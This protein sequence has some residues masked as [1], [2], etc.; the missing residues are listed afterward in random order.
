MACRP[1]F[2]TAP[3]HPNFVEVKLVEFT[4]YAG[5]S[6]SQK[7]K[8]IDSLHSEIVAPSGEILE[9]SSKSREELGV[10]LSA[11]NLSFV[12]AKYPNSICIESAFQGSKVFEH[13]GPLHHL[14][15]MDARESKRTVREESL[16]SILEFNFFG[17]AWPTRPYT[18]FYDWIYMQALHRNKK[19]A[20]QLL[21]RSHFTDIE[22]NPKKS[23]NC[24]A[25][26]AAL[27][28][29]LS[30]RGILEEVLSNKD[31]YIAV[32]GNNIDWVIQQGY[33]KYH[34]G[35]PML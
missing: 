21:S 31:A 33:G 32:M 28:V 12:H 34:S 7:Q 8:S 14:Y 22:F 13:G 9:V 23:I 17:Q 3:D 24:Q 30:Q 20:S 5:M 6:A 16:G 35:P 25:Y 10:L 29:S 11:F 18:L 1:V 4:W 15:A 19:L 2:I 26:S 27:Y